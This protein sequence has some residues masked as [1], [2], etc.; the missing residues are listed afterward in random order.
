M[1]E[2]IEKLKKNMPPSQLLELPCN[3]CDLN[4]C[5]LVY[6]LIAEIE[7]L[8][9]EWKRELN[10]NCELLEERKGEIK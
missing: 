8:D 9:D 3:R 4:H 10:I 6:R 7:F 5:D 2:W 1:K